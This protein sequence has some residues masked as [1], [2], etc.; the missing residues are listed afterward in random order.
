MT[1]VIYCKAEHDRLGKCACPSRWRSS[2][3]APASQPRSPSPS[4]NQVLSPPTMAAEWSDLRSDHDPAHLLQLLRGETSCF[5]VH[6]M[7]SSPGLVAGN[8]PMLS[9]LSKEPPQPL[10]HRVLFLG[11]PNSLSYD[12]PVRLPP[13]RSLHI[14][15]FFKSLL[16]ARS[17]NSVVTLFPSFLQWVS[18]SSPCQPRPSFSF[19]LSRSA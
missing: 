7:G 13:Y 10:R 12:P 1:E 18:T 17:S 4:Q 3:A 19:S 15:S 14:S 5:W 2:P 16:H 11:A 8:T 6:L 9:Y